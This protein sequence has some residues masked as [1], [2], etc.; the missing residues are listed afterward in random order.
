MNELLGNQLFWQCISYSG[1]VSPTFKLDLSIY[2]VSSVLN[3]CISSPAYLE[4]F[5]HVVLKGPKQ[6]K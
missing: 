3:F 2:R 4:V 1:N 5:V 6:S